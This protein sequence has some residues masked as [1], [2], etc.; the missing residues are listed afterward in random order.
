MNPKLSGHPLPHP[1]MNQTR[2][3]LDL[4]RIY[5]E[6]SKNNMNEIIPL[7]YLNIYFITI[8]FRQHN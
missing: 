5:T 2:I 6:F 4:F 7:C 8:C 3:K 1:I